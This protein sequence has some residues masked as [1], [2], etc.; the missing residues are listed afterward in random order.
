PARAKCSISPVRA[1]ARCAV[2]HSCARPAAFSTR[3]PTSSCRR[4]PKPRP[5][6]STKRS[7]PA[8]RSTSYSNSRSNELQT[9]I[10][11]ALDAYR[12]FI[13][14]DPQAGRAPVAR[15]FIDQLTR[16]R[17]LI[18]NTAPTEVTHE[19]EKQVI[20]QVSR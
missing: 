6:P 3:S 20:V 4:A 15:K 16:A 5:P 19:V 13:E 18:A 12:R 9:L 8:P 7:S 1:I 17:S 11:G 10:D 2:R 14:L